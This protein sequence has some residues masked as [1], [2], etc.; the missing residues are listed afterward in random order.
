MP[1][2]CPK[3]AIAMTGAHGWH[4]EWPR[5]RD[6][7]ERDLLMTMHGMFWRFPKTFSLAHSAGIAPPLH[8]S[9]GHP[10]FLPLGGSRRVRLRRCREG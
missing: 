4:T 7:G 6:I 9:Q 3:P 5:I 10:R 2:G 1:I 8:L